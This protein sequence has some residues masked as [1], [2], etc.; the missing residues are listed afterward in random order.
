MVNVK[1]KSVEG[2]VTAYCR[3]QDEVS[4]IVLRNERLALS[5][6]EGQHCDTKKA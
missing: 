1:F 5:T 2:T 6:K 4:N 3:K